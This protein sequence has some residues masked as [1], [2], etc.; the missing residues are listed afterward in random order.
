MET[1]LPLIERTYPV[2]FVNVGLSSLEGALEDTTVEPLLEL[3]EMLDTTEVEV[4]LERE[5]RIGCC[6]SRFSLSYEPL[7]IRRDTLG[8][9]AAK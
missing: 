4:E 7:M 3:T 6:G 5:E 8:L 2:N 1:D 9:I